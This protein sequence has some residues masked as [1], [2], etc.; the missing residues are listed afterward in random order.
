M[1]I[2]VYEVD[3][4]S[5][6]TEYPI[7]IALNKLGHTSVM[8]NWRKFLF[9][10]SKASLT[11]RILDKIGFDYVCYKINHSLRD[12]IKNQKFDLLIVVRGEHLYPETISF[13]KR[14]IPMVVNWNSDDLFNKLNGSRFIKDSFRLYDI[15]FSPR[16]DLK[17]EYLDK[18]AK[19]FEFINW[20]YRD[21]AVIPKSL[22]LGN[23]YK[24]D[25]SFVGSWSKRRNQILYSLP[26]CDLNIFGWGWKKKQELKDK[27]N[28]KI[29]NHVSIREMMKIYSQ[30]KIN[31]NILT[32]ENRDSINLR[33]FEVPI[34]GGFQISERTEEILNM[35]EED[36]EIV[37]FS[38]NEE[39]SSKIHFY[40]KNENSRDKIRIA[41]YHKVLNS[42]NELADRLSQIIN[43]S[44]DDYNR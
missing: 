20:Y 35:F 9:A 15:H 41:G 38:S 7:Q 18:G 40:L 21:E 22:I 10:Y 28:F 11:N 31:I 8:F 6:G 29:N 44:F 1:H 27:L 39:L 25:L 4:L 3:F 34:A 42:K 12:V 23:N 32:K 14:H 17:M 2:L 33:N 16:R 43:T 37:L 36:K 30:T 19:R 5:S 26:D 24:Y 13:L